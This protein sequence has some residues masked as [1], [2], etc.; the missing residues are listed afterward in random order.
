MLGVQVAKSLG[1]ETGGT[2]PP[3]MRQETHTVVVNPDTK[4]TKTIYG[5]TPEEAY[6]YGF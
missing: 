1:Y 5:L 2:L 3:R 4:E 6:E